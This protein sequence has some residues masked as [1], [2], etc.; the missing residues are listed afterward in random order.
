MRATP[1][2]SRGFL[3]RSIDELKRL[4]NIGIPPSSS[5]SQ[6]CQLRGADIMAFQR[7]NSRAL[8]AHPV[9]TNCTPSDPRSHST[10]AKYCQ[11]LTLAA[12]R[13]RTSTG[14]PHSL[15]QIV[16]LRPNQRLAMP[17]STGQ[18][19]PSYQKTGQT[20]SD[21]GMRR[22]EHKTNSRHCLAGVY[23]TSTHMPISRYA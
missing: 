6:T 8:R 9:P 5:F 18:S 7:L 21:R 3:G 11:M 12:F 1:C 2:L 23:G 16:Y 17:G 15:P 19:L 20:S 10:P 22:G 13:R 4:S 14:S